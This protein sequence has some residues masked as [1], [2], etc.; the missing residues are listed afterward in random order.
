MPLDFTILSVSYSE[1]C[2][3]KFLVLWYP[4]SYSSSC[5]VLGQVASHSLFSDLF[6]RRPI[7]LCPLG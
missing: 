4:S 2:V 1:N 7:E 3:T 6:V 5:Q